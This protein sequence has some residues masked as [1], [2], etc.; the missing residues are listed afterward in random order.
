MK[1]EW[2]IITNSVGNMNTT[3]RGKVPGGW[4]VKNYSQCQTESQSMIF[5]SDPEHKWN[6][7]DEK[8]LK[9]IK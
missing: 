9:D 1:Y 6:I 7:E 5:I 4:I 8:E 2:E 3:H